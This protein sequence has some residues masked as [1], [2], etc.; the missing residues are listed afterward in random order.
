MQA[1]FQLAKKFIGI[2]WKPPTTD[3]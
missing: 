1:K 3:I 2:E